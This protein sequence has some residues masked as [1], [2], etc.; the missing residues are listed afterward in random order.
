MRSQ[1]SFVGLVS[2]YLIVEGFLEEIEATLQAEG[3][4]CAKAVPRE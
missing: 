4:A 3:V 2:I 1:K